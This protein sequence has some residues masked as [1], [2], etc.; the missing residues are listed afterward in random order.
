MVTRPRV[1]IDERATSKRVRAMMFR[2][3]SDPFA[4]SDDHLDNGIDSTRIKVGVMR[5]MEDALAKGGKV[6]SH[7][8]RCRSGNGTVLKPTA[9]PEPTDLNNISLQFAYDETLDSE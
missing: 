3:A 2:P 9:S 4:A 7:K 1:A 5:R 6:K 8:L